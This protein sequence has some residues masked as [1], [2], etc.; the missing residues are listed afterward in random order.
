M[1]TTIQIPLTDALPADDEM[2]FVSPDRDAT[3]FVPSER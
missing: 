3:G 1:E 2:L